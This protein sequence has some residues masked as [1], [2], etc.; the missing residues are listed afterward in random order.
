M[1]PPL[2]ASDR[3]TSHLDVE[4][5][6]VLAGARALSV[7]VPLYEPVLNLTLGA[8]RSER[9]GGHVR[10]ERA[11]DVVA[12]LLT[13]K[14]EWVAADGYIEKQTSV[15]SAGGRHPLTALVLSKTEESR[16]DAWAISPST[17]PRR[18]QVT[19]HRIEV[20]TVLRATTDALRLPGEPES[21]IVL[22]ARFRR[23]LSKYPDGE[24]L[25]WRDSGV[26]L[27]SAHLIATNLGLRSCIAGIAETTQF[28]LDGSTDVLVDVGAILLSEKE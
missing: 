6:Q 3:D 4:D 28:A 22:L 27:G 19:G 7:P 9:A 20:R 24:T 12:P 17:A 11:V 10:L 2:P 8:R 21:L 16:H 5:A 26:F 13:A 1:R 14:S 25:V 18:Y 23:T 15:P